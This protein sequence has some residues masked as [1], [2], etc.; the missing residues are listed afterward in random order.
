MSAPGYEQEPLEV[1]LR[2]L[3]AISLVPSPTRRDAV[4]RL[5]SHLDE[6]LGALD[7]LERSGGL[8]VKERQQLEALRQLRSALEALA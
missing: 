5:Q 4:A 8:S 7:G 3:L 6:A 1:V 2:S